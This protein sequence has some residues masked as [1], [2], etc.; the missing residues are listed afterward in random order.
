M[1]M[2]GSLRAVI[3]SSR[4]NLSHSGDARAGHPGRLAAILVNIV[5]SELDVRMDMARPLREE[6]RLPLS[7]RPPG[8]DLQDTPQVLRA[9]VGPR[10]RV[11]M[12]FRRMQR[13]RSEG[14]CRPRVDCPD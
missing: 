12:L 13:C 4:V 10:C 11:S 14:W 5:I 8:H 6:R 3:A 7:V 9:V 2:P 1:S